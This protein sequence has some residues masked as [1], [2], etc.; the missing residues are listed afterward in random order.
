ML[1]CNKG[2][3]KLA[4]LYIHMSAEKIPPLF[5]NFWGHLNL[6]AAI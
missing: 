2:S 3:K 4:S 1:V 6:A 5:H